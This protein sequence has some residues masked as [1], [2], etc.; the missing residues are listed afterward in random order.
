MTLMGSNDDSLTLDKGFVR[1]RRPRICILT[2]RGFFNNAFRCG[3]YEGQD[4]LSEVDDVDLLYLKPKKAYELRERFQRCIIWRDFTGKIVSMNMAYQPIRLTKEYDLFIVY[5]PYRS[6][7]IQIPAIQGWKDYCRTSILWID[8]LWASIVPK[9]KSY[10]SLFSEFDHVAI[11]LKGTV[12]VVSDAIKRPCHWVPGGIDTI[13]FSPY[14]E[15]PVRAIDIY[16]IGRMWKGL[17]QALLKYAANNRLFYVYDTFINA[18]DR[19][20]KECRLHR[21]MIANIAKRSRYFLVAPAKIDDTW[22]RKRQIEVGFRYYEGSAAGAIML[23]QILDCESFRTMFDWPDSVIEIKPDGS[24][25]AQVLTSLAAQPERL[26]EISRRNAIEALLRHDWVYRW[27]KILD[28]AGLKPT[29]ELEIRE[30]R[31]KR[32]A[33]QIG[34]SG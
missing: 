8:E 2:T 31:L 18:S 10:L 23:G 9:L 26:L 4:V 32:M 33:E 34:N 7:M 14:P 6:D 17:H 1:R 20:V 30:N 28:I 25:V 22:E 3:F 16:S 19:Q 21:E 5:L 15:F 29:P 27:K 13:R 11:G 24:D 12:K